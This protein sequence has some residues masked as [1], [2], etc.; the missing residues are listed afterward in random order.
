M[1]DEILTEVTRKNMFIQ[2]DALELIESSGKDV[3]FV[4][5]LLSAVSSNKFLVTKKDVE[6]FLNGDKGLMSPEKIVP[7]KVN[8]KGEFTVLKATDITGNSTCEAKVEDFIKYFKSRYEI[9]SNILKDNNPT[10]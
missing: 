1:K 4:R 5:S 9:L 8:P 6:D 10:F 7:N 3:V 2:P